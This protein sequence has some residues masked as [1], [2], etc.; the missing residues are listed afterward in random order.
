M[1]A[2]ADDE[3]ERERNLVGMRGLADREPFGEVVEPDPGGDRH[4]QMERLLS[5]AD[6]GLRERHRAGTDARAAPSYR[7]AHVQQA[8]Q[9]H[10]Q[11]EPVAKG[12]S[13]EPHPGAAVLG[14][15]QGPVE[16]VARVREDVHQ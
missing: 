1:Q 9:A 15:S 6:G 3:Q 12:Q 7:L 11:P 8:H 16:D 13:R 10:A 4:R 5:S 14:G 2:E